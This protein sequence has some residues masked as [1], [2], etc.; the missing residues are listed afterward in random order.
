M[1][2]NFLV[3]GIFLQPQRLNS[4]A[5]CA[6]RPVRWNDGFGVIASERRTGFTARMPESDNI[7]KLSANAVVE[8]VL[9]SDQVQSANNVGTLCFNSGADTGFF[10][11]Q[12]QGGL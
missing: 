5:G 10:N 3:K 7:K 12:G 9:N 1:V 11:E 2:M 8:K 4:P 6:F